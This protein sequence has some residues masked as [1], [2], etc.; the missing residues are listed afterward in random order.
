MATYDVDPDKAFENALE[1][2]KKQ[3]QDLRLPL[4]QISQDFYKSQKAIFQLK[5]PGQYPDLAPDGP[6]KSNYKARKKKIWGFIY[7]ILRAS[8]KLEK[9]VTKPTDSE[10]I[11]QI[12]NKDTLIIGTKVDYG[13]FHQL[14][15]PKIPQRKFLFIGPEAPSVAKGPLAGRAERWLNTINAFVLK[16]MEKEGFDVGK[17]F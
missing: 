9:S 12:I 11:N 8:G 16:T 5:G 17:D 3:V 2:A 1:R 7:P 10:A 14:G 4:T 6:G 13:K 15:G